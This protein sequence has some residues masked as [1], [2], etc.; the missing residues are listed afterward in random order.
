MLDMLLAVKLLL[1]P[2]L[3]AVVTLV[4]RR[5]GAVTAG[6]LSAF[7]ILSGPILAIIAIEQG[8]E[9]AA[10]AAQG[11]LLA[12]LALLVFSL[13]YAWAA[14]SRSWP[15]CLFVALATYG[16]AVIGLRLVQAPL[17]M[18][19]VTVL[20]GLLLAPLA[21][22]RV[23]AWVREKS[24]GKDLPWRMLAAAVL[25]LI[26][27]SAAQALGP[28]LAGLLAMFPVM[29]TVLVGFTHRESGG[30]VAIRMLR[31]MIYGYFGFAIFCATLALALPALPILQSFAL[32]LAA[33]IAVHAGVRWWMP[34]A[35]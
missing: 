2:L 3:I 11:T 32:A 12:V 20:A 15:H 9:F 8:P 30:A 18:T 17:G 5:Y 34:R 10:A 21:F 29:S 26:V 14:E 28:R 16:L 6:W 1:V 7:P 25:V 27:T 24:S 19:L 31:G 22:P 4:G 33:A 23:P 35:A 13:S